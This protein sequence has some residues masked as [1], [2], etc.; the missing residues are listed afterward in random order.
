MKFKYA[1]RG[2]G[3]NWLK[4]FVCGSVNGGELE[5]DGA[6]YRGVCQADMAAYVENEVQGKAV[7]DLF[8]QFAFAAWLDFRPNENKGTQVKIGACETHLEQLRLIERMAYENNGIDSIVLETVRATINTLRSHREIE[9]K[10][11]QG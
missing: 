9:T 8:Q 3:S 11:D 7:V 1:P 2:L 5:P 4:C 6:H 10:G